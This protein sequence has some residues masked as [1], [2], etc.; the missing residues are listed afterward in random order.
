[1][2][3]ADPH[4]EF[5]RGTGYYG[6]NGPGRKGNREFQ[7][8]ECVTQAPRRSHSSHKSHP[9]HESHPQDPRA[10]ARGL[11]LL[12]LDSAREDG[13][14]NLCAALNL[15]AYLHRDPDPWSERWIWCAAICDGMIDDPANPKQTLAY[16]TRIK[17]IVTQF[18]AD[19][20]A[21]NRQPVDMPPPSRH[22]RGTASPSSIAN[23][24][25]E[26]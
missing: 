26:I 5:C 4:C 8:C 2:S 20:E 21:A 17:A 24:Q 13:H 6:D 12:L 7:L 25:S 11:S 10:T 1:M 16:A 15:A 19:Q 18:Q 9:S 14:P 22:G 23:H 3:G